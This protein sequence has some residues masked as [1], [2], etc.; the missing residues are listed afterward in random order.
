MGL[1]FG[2]NEKPPAVGQD[3]DIELTDDEF[4]TLK[5]NMRR[6]IAE[7]EKRLEAEVAD[8]IDPGQSDGLKLELPNRDIKIERLMPVLDS[9]NIVITSKVE[10]LGG[11]N[12]D[13]AEALKEDEQYITESHRYAVAECL[14]DAHGK[15]IAR[16]AVRQIVRE[17]LGD[18]FNAK[19]FKDTLFRVYLVSLGI[20]ERQ[21]AVSRQQKMEQERTEEIKRF[22]KSL[23]DREKA[24]LDMIANIKMISNPDSVFHLDSEF[25]YDLAIKMDFDNV[26]Q[27]VY[28]QLSRQIGK[29][30]KNPTTGAM[31]VV[32]A[33]NW[34][35]LETPRGKWFK[36][37]E[38]TMNSLGGKL[39]YLKNL[40]V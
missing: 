27:R 39:A 28:S 15:E 35:S 16:S 3:H 29:M 22:W 34:R 38:G 12:P 30:A 33:D 26:C 4:G 40:L 17:K 37:W 1:F 11:S 20:K 6:G 19:V 8:T 18:K 2:R 25:V 31:E 21:I 13:Q 36:N 24:F 10:T 23:S 32:T 5:A 14:I 7:E 9:S